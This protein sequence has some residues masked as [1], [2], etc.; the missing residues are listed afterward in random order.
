MEGNVNLGICWLKTQL[1]SPS[2]DQIACTWKIK[3]YLWECNPSKG[4][5]RS[6]CLPLW[7]WELWKWN[8]FISLAIQLSERNTRALLTFDQ[9]LQRGIARWPVAL[10]IR[11]H[12][13]NVLKEKSPKTPFRPNSN[14]FVWRWQAVDHHAKKVTTDTMIDDSNGRR[15]QETRFRRKETKNNPKKSDRFVHLDGSIRGDA[16]AF[17]PQMDGHNDTEWEITLASRCVAAP[18]AFGL[19]FLED[20]TT[21]FWPAAEIWRRLFCTLSSKEINVFFSSFSNSSSS[22]RASSEMSVSELCCTLH[23]NSER[24]SFSWLTPHVSSSAFTRSINKMT[25]KKTWQNHRNLTLVT[26]GIAQS[27]RNRTFRRIRTL[28][29]VFCSVCRYRILE[30]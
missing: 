27:A 3:V 21:F 29:H 12:C 28:V 18:L 1:A 15:Q 23:S 11:N 6:D 20:G 19:P 5:V 16:R 8:R 13:R 7:L 10:M 22:R 26:N 24:N 17:L 4:S 14:G 25:A 2:T 30:Q 9:N